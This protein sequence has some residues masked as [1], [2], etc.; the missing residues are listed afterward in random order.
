MRVHSVAG[1]KRL[2]SPE[3]ELTCDVGRTSARAHVR[4]K[5]RWRTIWCCSVPVASSKRS[6]MSVVAFGTARVKVNG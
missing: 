5:V 3:R 1:A 6:S 2:C 4:G